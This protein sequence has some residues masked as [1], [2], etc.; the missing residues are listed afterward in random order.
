MTR[1]CDHS[2]AADGV[3][4][5]DQFLPHPPRTVWQALVDP[6]KLAAWFMPNDFAPVVGH[7]FTFHRK[8]NPV[9]RF[10]DTIACQVLELREHELLSYSWTDGGEY[11][12]DLDSTVTW[13]LRPEGRG[14]RLFLQHRGFRP[15]DPAH[16][17][18]RGLM[19]GGWRIYLT[20]RLPAFLSDS[21]QPTVETQRGAER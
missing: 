5:V 11:A 13:T 16:Q 7:R 8:A 2:D 12:G 6:V 20:D 4:V 17:A 3:I 15:D 19:T 21:D 9:V 1:Q 10:S 18:A 14:T